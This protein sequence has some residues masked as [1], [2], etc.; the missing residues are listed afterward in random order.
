MRTTPGGKF[1][2]SNAMTLTRVTRKPQPYKI[3]AW[4]LSRI[5]RYFGVGFGQ[6]RVNFLSC[7]VSG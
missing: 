4:L 6:Q 7:S 3:Q 1:T 2:W 5:H